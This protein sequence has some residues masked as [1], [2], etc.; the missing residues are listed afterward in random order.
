MH[1]QLVHWFF[2]IFAGAAALAALALFTRTPLL[3][4]YI[5][6]GCAFGPHS[7]AL[8]A[9]AATISEIAE[10]GIIF[11]LFLLGLDMQPRN[12]T[13][14]LRESF[15]VAVLSSI[16]FFAIG[17]G[18]AAVAGATLFEAALVG[19]AATFSSTIIGIK[20]LPTTVLHHRHVGELLVSLLL[21]QDLI[22]ILVLVVIG[23]GGGTE[24]ASAL[25]YVRPLLALPVVIAAAFVGVRYLILPLV[26]RF[27]VFHEFLFLVAIGWCLTVAVVARELGLSFEIGAFIAGISLATHPIAQ[28]MAEN[29]RPLRDFF[30]VLFFFSVG[31]SF[32]PGTLYTVLMPA[33]VLALVLMAAKPIVFRIL[34]VRAGETPSTAWEVGCR[35]G[36]MSEFSLMIAYLGAERGL[37]GADASHLI[38][39][40]AILTFLLSSYLVVFRFPS[41]ISP[42]ERLRRD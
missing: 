40:A 25:D 33:I 9:D 36:Q 38:Q 31:A 6:I 28:Y 42:L 2:L 10:I 13:R 29:L 21:L 8:I 22:A 4:A 14:L 41:P 24:S 23:V 32:N 16:A 27:D 15:A 11:L 3:I 1:G 5:L 26:A 12:L 17:A 39:G 34:L 18:I 35:L 7:L 19:G 20:L 37:L 30:L